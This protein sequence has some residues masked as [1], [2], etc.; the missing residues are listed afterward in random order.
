MKKK[1]LVWRHGWHLLFRTNMGD[2]D[3]L[4]AKLA[5]VDIQVPLS[6]DEVKSQ[7]GTGVYSFK[8]I[9]T[10]VEDF[11]ERM[12]K[13]LKPHGTSP[14]HRKDCELCDTKG[15]LHNAL[16][17][18]KTKSSL[19]SHIQKCHVEV[20]VTPVFCG[21][22]GDGI[23]GKKGHFSA[24]ETK[25]FE[26]WFSLMDHLKHSNIHN[27]NRVKP[28]P[29]VNNRAI[30]RTPG[31]ASNFLYYKK[32]LKLK[33]NIKFKEVTPE[34]IA[35]EERML[36]T[37]QPHGTVPPLKVD[38]ELCDTKGL[39]HNASPSRKNHSSLLQ[40]IREHHTNILVYPVFC[41]CDGGYDGV[42]GKRGHFTTGERAEKF[43]TWYTLMKHLQ[44]NKFHNPDPD[45]EYP[46]DFE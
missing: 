42:M 22:D 6:Y 37:I 16:A 46:E 4:V 18:S 12:R 38:C 43:E 26:T 15:L 45:P 30:A 3:D 33:G 29:P 24:G 39:L 41:G 7:R 10:E 34:V 28:E 13:D 21:C 36:K 2:V 5:K 44:Q 14:V 9:A 27:P 8:P 23:K 1:K 11:R 25:P 32:M 19:L 20:F 40:H 35:F 17:T 31:R